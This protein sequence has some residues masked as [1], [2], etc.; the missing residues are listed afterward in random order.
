MMHDRN[1]A[2]PERIEWFEGMLHE[3]REKLG[4][5]VIEHELG[6]VHVQVSGGAVMA[7]PKPGDALHDSLQVADT[8]LYENK[9]ASGTIR[10][11]EL[12]RAA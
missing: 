5:L 9:R 4:A 6:S 3:L 8:N 7:W 2:V 11:T 12:E 1:M 10:W